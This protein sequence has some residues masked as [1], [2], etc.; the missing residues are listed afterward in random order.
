VL[1]TYGGT[2]ESVSN[3][4]EKA[5]DLRVNII[6]L[7][8]GGEVNPFSTETPLT[9]KAI[10]RAYQANI[11]V[12]VAAGNSAQEGN[13]LNQPASCPHA[14]S[15]AAVNKNLNPTSFSSFDQSVTIAAPG[16]DIVSTLPNDVN[17]QPRYEAWSGTSMATP[18]VSATIA[19]YLE[20]YPDSKVDEVISAIENTAIDLGSDGKDAYT[21]YGLINP[22][23]L[24]TGKEANLAEIRDGICE[25]LTPAIEYLS[26]VK[27]K[28]DI[29]YNPVTINKVKKIELILNFDDNTQIVKNLPS[30]K[31]NFTFIIKED[32]SKI[33]SAFLLQEDKVNNTLYSNLYQDIVDATPLKPTKI[34]PDLTSLKVTYKGEKIL[35]SYK[36]N[37]LYDKNLSLTIFNDDI[38]YF[39]IV[40]FKGSAKGEYLYTVKN[41]VIYEH[42]LSISLTS[43]S[44]TISEFLEPKYLVA[45]NSTPAIK[46]TT[47]SISASFLCIIKAPICKKARA[48]LYIDGKM[49]TTIPLTTL[50]EGFYTSNKKLKNIKVT[51]LTYESRLIK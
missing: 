33:T 17:N 4:I 22:L 8:L 45:L 3:G 43:P 18:V 48:K 24:L 31:N 1:S 16:E 30:S 40:E 46:G 15:V 12:V 9:C 28:I 42:A 13:P 51:V 29:V 20:K 21:G 23:T 26:F 7:S 27:K 39:D 38:N 11:V 19:L 35:I 37:P 6:N 10:E 49:V 44:N 50:G 2:D 14:I 32:P 25:K 47:I 36:I 41:P 5:V 34:N